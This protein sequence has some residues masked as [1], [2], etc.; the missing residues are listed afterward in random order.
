MRR[1][2]IIVI[3]LLFCAS[4]SMPETRIYSL[5]I[6][7]E[8]GKGTAMAEASI[9][10]HIDS[11]KYLTQPYI[12]FRSSPY[13][14]EISKYAKWDASPHEMIKEELRHALSSMGLFREVRVSRTIPGGFYLFKIHLRRF[15]RF[16]SGNESFGDLVLV[17][18][19]LSPDSTELYQ[20]TVSK[21]VKLD[22]R[23]FLSLAK[24]LSSV[25]TEGMEEIMS[26]IR[27]SFECIR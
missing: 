17:F 16:D 15:E 2:L 14:L 3:V 25:L 9:V 4:C 1:V 7:R 13:Q 19:L 5:Y 26:A 21:R 8:E 12:A 22:D 6:P 18:S 11:Q 20:G 24:G 10:I 27:K 23:S